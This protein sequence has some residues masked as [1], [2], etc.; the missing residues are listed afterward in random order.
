MSNKNN[1]VQD[2]LKERI[3]GVTNNPSL[4]RNIYKDVKEYSE[5]VQIN[6]LF[7]LEDR[8]AIIR[9]PLKVECH[10]V[11]L[12][13]DDPLSWTEFC[14]P[15]DIL[16]SVNRFWFQGF[17]IDGQESNKVFPVLYFYIENFRLPSLPYGKRILT[18]CFLSDF[19]KA[20]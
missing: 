9:R 2:K 16:L 10:K 1:D 13:K 12:P 3:R 14:I 8:E 7:F 17:L 11:D 19:I 20:V 15:G 6:F 18:R 5:G 4:Q